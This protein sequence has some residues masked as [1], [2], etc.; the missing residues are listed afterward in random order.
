MRV[1][2]KSAHGNE[3]AT[4]AGDI[5][6]FSNCGK[7]YG[8][9]PRPMGTALVVTDIKRDE[10]GEPIWVGVRNAFNLTH[11]RIFPDQLTPVPYGTSLEDAL[12]DTLVALS[13]ESRGCAAFEKTVKEYRSLV[14]E[15]KL[16]PI[17]EN[18]VVRSS[19]TPSP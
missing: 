15:G 9:L 5:Y 16:E 7:A 3:R 14:A 11:F 18:R 17:D 2:T 13:D 10:Q 8:S 4:N 6:L 12:R 19:S 1:P